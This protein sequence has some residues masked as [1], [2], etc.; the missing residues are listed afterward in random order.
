MLQKMS[1]DLSA[2]VE[3]AQTADESTTGR[4]Q[5]AGQYEHA[6]GP[7]LR[8]AVPL[9]ACS[10]RESLS[11]PRLVCSPPCLLP[12]YV[13]VLV[14]RPMLD[15]ALCQSQ[16]LSVAGGAHAR[17]GVRGRLAC[18]QV[19]PHTPRAVRHVPCRIRTTAGR[20]G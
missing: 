14:L 4:V 18:A 6:R 9:G 5:L 12:A 1:T 8:T 15:T 13:D 7:R 19:P 16:R 20:A 10:H 11:A 3:T 2:A 17:R